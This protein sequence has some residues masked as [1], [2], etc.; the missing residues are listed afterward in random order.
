MS[1]SFNKSCY[2]TT[3]KG[4]RKNMKTPVTQT[5]PYVTFLDESANAR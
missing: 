1:N 4:K 3:Q 2:V 5:R